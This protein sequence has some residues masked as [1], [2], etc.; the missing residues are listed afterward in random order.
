MLFINIHNGS[1]V[2]ND[3]EPEADFKPKQTE[4]K[5]KNFKKKCKKWNWDPLLIRTV[6]SINVLL[7]YI[8]YIIEFWKLY[9][10]MKIISIKWK[11]FDW[12]FYFGNMLG[13]KYPNTYEY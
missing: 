1:G 10:K 8:F 9:C 7:V 2:S 3:S 12:F 4:F 6:T 13:Y 5:K 11:V